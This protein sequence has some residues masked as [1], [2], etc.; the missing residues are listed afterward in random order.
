MRKISKRSVFIIINILLCLVV[1]ACAPTFQG[2]ECI[3]QGV[4]NLCQKE[5]GVEV[6]VK[7]VDATLCVRIPLEGVFDSNTMQIAPEALKKID[8]VMLSVSRVSLS[9]DAPILFYKVITID[10]NIPGIEVTITRYVNDLKRY[11]YGDI[12]RGEFTKRMIFDVQ[13]LPQAA[14]SDW[15]NDFNPKEMV[16]ED[17]ISWQAV[18]RIADE[19]KEDK[20]LAGKFKLSACEGNLQ[21]GI[22]QFSVEIKREG[23]P[24]SELIHGIEWHST[25]LELC[26]KKIAHVIY[27]YGY[28]DFDRVEIVNQFDNKL[29]IMQKDEINDWRKRRIEIE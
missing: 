2:N 13:Y 16:I 14:G 25:V 8:G 6:D 9:C 28:E 12:S 18:R 1:S 21:D 19:F 23:L 7:I 3:K 26:L 17:F 20:V 27:V 24:M 11:M 5:Y 29:M 22:F 10:N 4:K 15:L